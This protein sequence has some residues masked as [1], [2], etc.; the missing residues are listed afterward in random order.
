MFRNFF[1][2]QKKKKFAIHFMQFYEK[3][4]MSNFIISRG[5]GPKT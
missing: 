2:S 4:A 1:D 3:P 5:F